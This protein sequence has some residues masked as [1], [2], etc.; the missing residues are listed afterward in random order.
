MATQTVAVDQTNRLQ[1]AVD[2]VNFFSLGHMAGQ[3]SKIQT[4]TNKRYVNFAHAMRESKQTAYNVIS[5]STGTSGTVV[6]VL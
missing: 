2:L 4:C 1:K 3:K 5:Y 6:Q